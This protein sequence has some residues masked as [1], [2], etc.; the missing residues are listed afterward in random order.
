MFRCVVIFTLVLTCVSAEDLSDEMT[1]CRKKVVGKS[2]KAQSLHEY[3]FPQCR[4]VRIGV[5]KSLCLSEELGLIVENCPLEA[6][7][8]QELVKLHEMSLNG[9]DS[10]ILQLS[11]RGCFVFGLQ[12]ERISYERLFSC[13]SKQEH[14]LR[15]PFKLFENVELRRM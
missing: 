2:W 13:L 7:F 3:S 5:E 8:F 6:R 1:T 9:V 15:G 11:V 10:Q 12:M 4:N 14:L